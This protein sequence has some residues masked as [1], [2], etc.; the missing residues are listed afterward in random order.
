MTASSSVRPRTRLVIGG[1]GGLGAEIA[2]A[3]GDHGDPVLVADA[4]LDAAESVVAD[5]VGQG[6]A[7]TPAAVD[8]TD[9]RSVIAAVET[10]DAIG[11]GLVAV[12]NAAGVPGR[13][14]FADLDD[15]RWQRVMDVN[16]RG[17]FLV[18]SAAV[19]VLRVRRSGVLVSIASVAGVRPS[20][21]SVAYSASKAGV[22]AMSRSLA[23]EVAAEGVR[24]WAV[25]P[26]AIETGMFLRMLHD[27]D[28]GA[29]RIAE[30]A[31]RPLGRV[32]TAAEIAAH[33][34]FLVDGGGPP[35]VADGLVW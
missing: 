31:A 8:V 34:A 20:P 22:V 7:A 1:G 17:A 18:A 13:I 29:R 21:G 14:P 24:V 10:A 2:R 15:A 26:P 19:R 25:C 5:L 16:L 27:D 3:L 30:E 6:I 11:G 28:D 33:V 32:V 23:A 4:D 12:V 35:Y 9:E